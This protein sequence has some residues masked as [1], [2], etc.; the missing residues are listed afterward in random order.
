MKI[1]SLPLAALL[2]VTLPFLAAIPASAAIALP[3]KVVL[4][5]AANETTVKLE[6]PGQQPALVQ[7]W[8]DD[9]NEEARPE[10]LAL[11]FLVSPSLFRLEPQSAQQVR[12]HYLPQGEA[13]PGDR[14]SLYHLNVL[15]VPPSATDGSEVEAKLLLAVQYRLRLLYRPAAMKE[16]DAE[17]RAHLIEWSWQAVEGGGMELLARNPTPYFQ[18]FRKVAV[19]QGGQEVPL[20][21]EPDNLL[22]PFSEQRFPLPAGWTPR[23]EARIVFAIADDLSQESPALQAQ[24]RY[25][26]P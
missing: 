14:E 2:A 24:A 20:P 17:V 3:P 9:G 5:G 4:S 25:A 15:D 11:P 1:L 10:D 16:D 26:T 19:A 8:I 18:F 7:V 22:A 13:L 23:T 12:I 6:N 21:L